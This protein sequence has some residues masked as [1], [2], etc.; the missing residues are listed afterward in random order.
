MSGD[1]IAPIQVVHLFVVDSDFHIEDSPSDNMELK[2]DVSY[3]DVHLSKKGNDARASL[4][5]C[6]IGSLLDRDE[7]AQEKMHAGVTVSI[8]VSAQMPMNS[9][10]DEARHYLL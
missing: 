2:V 9:P 8:S 6:V 10:D 1:F 7:G 4:K 5:M 3:Q